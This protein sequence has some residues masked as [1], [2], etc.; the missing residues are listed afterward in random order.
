MK[1]KFLFWGLMV[2]CSS[3]LYAM[4]TSNSPGSPSKN[5]NFL[6]LGIF[7]STDSIKTSVNLEVG[8]TIY[9]NERFQLRSLTAITGSKIF[10]DEPN[11]YQLGLMEKLTFGQ[12]DSCSQPISAPDT[13]SVLPAL[14]SCPLTETGHP[15][16]CSVRPI[17]GK[18]VAVPE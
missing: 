18:W 4:T 3:M 10:D 9:S 15:S 11:L 17:T 14:A 8:L 1:Q 7:S 12:V 13:D 6:S 5:N 2:L 16:F